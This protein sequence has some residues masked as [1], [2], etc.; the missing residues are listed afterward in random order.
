MLELEL[1]LF[2]R[3]KS[4]NDTFMTYYNASGANEAAKFG[5]SNTIYGGTWN[6]VTLEAHRK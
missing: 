4:G 3:W 1:I 2:N 6:G 5:A